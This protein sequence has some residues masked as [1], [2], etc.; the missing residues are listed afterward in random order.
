MRSSLLLYTA[1]IAVAVFF[2][3]HRNEEGMFPLSQL[4]QVDFKAAGFKISQKDIYNPDGVALTD[5]LVRLGGCTGSFISPEGLIITNHHCVYGSVAGVSTKEN[6]YL[7]K[8]FYA[9]QKSKEIKVGLPCKITLGYEDVSSKVLEGVSPMMDPSEKK[10]IIRKNADA[11]IKAANAMNPGFTYEISEM[12]VGVSYTL[13]KYMVLKDVRLVY[14]PPHDIGNFGGETDNWEWPKHTGDFSVVR[15]YVGKDGKPAE[16]SPDNVPYSPRKFL[17][18]NPHGTRNNDLVF[19]LGYPGTTFRHDPYQFIEYQ[20]KFV[21]PFISEWYG[22]RIRTMEKLGK[23]NRDRELRLSGTVKSLANTKKNFEGKMF[24]LGQTGLL[25]T[26]KNEQENL[27]QTMKNKGVNTAFFTQIDSLYKIKLMYAKRSLLLNRFTIDCGVFNTALAIAA[28]KKS[29]STVPGPDDKEFWNKWKKQ[30][31]DAQAQTRIVDA[32][33]EQLVLAELLTRT[34]ALKGE[35]KVASLSKLKNPRKWAKKSFK[36]SVIDDVEL[37]NKYLDSVPWEVY[38]SKDPIVR[39][40]DEMFNDLKDNE[41][42]NLSFSNKMSSLLPQLLDAR[43]NYG[44]KQ[45]IPDANS[46]LRFTYGHISGY[47]EGLN[48]HP[49][50]Y[51]FRKEI[52]EKNQ[53]DNADYELSEETRQMLKQSQ[54]APQ[55]IDPETGDVVICMLYNMDTTGGNSGSPVMDSE[56][57]LIG[58]NFDRAYTATLN[59]YS[60]NADYSRSIAVDIRYVLYTMKYFSNATGLLSEIGVQL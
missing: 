28:S 36:V 42:M 39:L 8:G 20:Q 26:K 37:F 35:M 43:I 1:C 51:T 13:F 45:F 11:I 9:D 55:L 59:D 52:F 30:I 50:P 44:N 2:S 4:N 16:Y 46:T 24:G 53:K 40:A 22:W 14:V 57:N 23:G 25:E 12:F 29:Q 15:A 56:G 27:M 18:I 10:A 38:H 17:K 5:A 3:S 21:L 19:I 33:L 7:K 32:E 31:K 60:W 58:V 54:V 49:F 48:P 47:K 34:K 41:T 6:D